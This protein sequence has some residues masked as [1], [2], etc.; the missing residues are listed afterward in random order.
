[1]SAITYSP[2]A[3]SGP[4]SVTRL[5]LTRRGRAIIA[6]IVSL[7]LMFALFSIALNG[8]GA[9]ATSATP[10][11]ATITVEGGESLW[12]VAAD[13]APQSPTADVV[14]DLIA[15][16]ELTSADLRPGQLLIIPARYVN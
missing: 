8:G 13:I 3:I 11:V 1:M 12:S 6:A 10:V 14:A 16:N 2:A 7:P 9:T 4:G 5:R 15:V